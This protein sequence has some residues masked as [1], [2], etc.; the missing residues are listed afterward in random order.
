MLAPC[1]D[2]MKDSKPP[3]LLP[4]ES[5]LDQTNLHHNSKPDLKDT[6]VFKAPTKD[7]LQ[8][9]LMIFGSDRIQM[10]NSVGLRVAVTC[11]AFPP[12]RFPTCHLPPVF[13]AVAV[14]AG[15]RSPSAGNA[16]S[17]KPPCSNLVCASV[18]LD[19]ESRL[20]LYQIC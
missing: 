20:T 18:T 9:G 6:E 12:A 10:S 7:S 4:L 3:V 19:V 17:P 1:D 13:A 5:L 16:S 2:D 14:C 8:E 15:C 11:P